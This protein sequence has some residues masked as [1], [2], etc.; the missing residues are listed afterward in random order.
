[1]QDILSL[2]YSTCQ[3]NNHSLRTAPCD[4]IS[5]ERC[6]RKYQVEGVLALFQIEI[7]PGERY[8]GTE[9]NLSLCCCTGCSPGQ[10][11]RMRS[12]GTSSGRFVVRSVFLIKK[13]EAL[14]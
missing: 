5:C 14:G 4:K 13:I 3:W 8:H 1:K 2:C 7:A 9:N 12:V 11:D 10:T 6:T